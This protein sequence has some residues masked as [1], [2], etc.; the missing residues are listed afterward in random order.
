M[1]PE[2]TWKAIYKDGTEL[3]QHNKDGTV[4]KYPDIDRSKLE[5][6]ELRQGKKLIFKLHLEPGR[7]LIVRR[8]TIQTL[9]GSNKQ[10][11]WMVGW[12]WNANGRN[13][14]DIAWI[15]DDGHMELTGRFK[16]MPF[17]APGKLMECEK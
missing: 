1:G 6:F 12:Q 15:F 5:F 10:V 16:E 14:Q 7:K 3:P 13:V 17:G 4:N 11:V 9:M 2:I 8:R